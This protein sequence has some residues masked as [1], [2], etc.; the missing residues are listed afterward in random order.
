MEA[1]GRDGEVCFHL[2]PFYE[3][4]KLTSSMKKHKMTPVS[5]GLRGIPKD[6]DTT[7]LEPSQDPREGQKNFDSPTMV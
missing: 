7:A 2:L 5:R 3:I 6:G 1:A 4:E